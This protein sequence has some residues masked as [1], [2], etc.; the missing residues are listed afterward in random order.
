MRRVRATAAA[1]AGRREASGIAA[2]LGRAAVEARRLR[3]LT[4]SQIAARVGCSRARYAELERGTGGAAP[5]ELWVKVGIALG[6]PLA[7]AFSRETLIDGTGSGP[8]DAGHLAAQELVLRLG[9]EHGRRASVE[10]PTSTRRSPLVG[11]VVLRD[12]RQ[13]V[14]LFIE[15]INRAGDLGATSRGSDRKAADLE[16]MALLIGGETGPYRV[17]VGWMLT[18]TAANRQLIASYPE[19]LRT[20]CPGSSSQLVAALTAG[21][22]PPQG[23]AIAWI[24]QRQSRIYALRWRSRG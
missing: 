21:S 4:Q 8:E 18:D 11:D 6:R 13:R 19:F 5:L 20:R 22:A 15:V 2:N 16:G 23:T 10:L 9:R 12:D 7:V 14:L 1:A 3:R 24:D 17:A